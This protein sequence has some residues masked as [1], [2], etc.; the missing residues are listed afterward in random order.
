[1][2]NFKFDDFLAFEVACRARGTARVANRLVR[3]LRDIVTNTNSSITVDKEIANKALFQLGIDTN[4]LDQTDQKYLKHLIQ[5][6][7]GGPVGLDTLAAQMG[8]QKDA[9]EDVIEP[10]LLQQGF[11]DR[12]PRGRVLSPNA[13]EHLGIQPKDKQTQLEMLSNNRTDIYETSRSDTDE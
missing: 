7:S 1:M 9:V 11:I 3:R 4:G 8:E 12:T 2:L 10:Y 13:Y 5:D 6:H